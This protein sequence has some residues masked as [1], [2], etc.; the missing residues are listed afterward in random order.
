MKYLYI[1]FFCFSSV[2]L[3]AQEYKM[4]VFDY[5]K[6]YFGENEPLPAEKF[7]M[8]TGGI[9]NNIFF[10]EVQVFNPKRNHNKNEP[11][12]TGEW[13]RGIQNQ[14]ALTYSVPINTKLRQKAQYDVLINFYRDISPEEKDSMRAYIFQGI[15][16]YIEQSYRQKGRK[17]T[18]RNPYKDVI[19]DLNDIVQ[20]RLATYRMRTQIKFKGFSDMVE[21]KV[22]EL[23][24]HKVQKENLNEKR[25]NKQKKLP[26]R[27]QLLQKLMELM[28]GELDYYFQLDIYKLLDDKYIRNY[29]TER[30]RSTVAINIGFGGIPLSF[31]AQNFNY[32]GAPY[33][34]MSFP[35]GRKAFRPFW[36]KMAFSAGVFIPVLF[37][38][39]KTHLTAPFTKIPI[40]AAVSYR[41]WRFLR[42]HA[43]ATVLEKP[44]NGTIVPGLDRDFNVRPFIGV[45]VELDMWLDFA[46]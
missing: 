33:V 43:G 20:G 5:E 4:V 38:K 34:G 1:A 39:H 30:T 21:V 3:F 15:H 42:I 24:E 25:Q 26:T 16:Q 36:H 10:V 27:E 31:N 41:P 2:F 44:V 17:V 13:K 29:P 8:L 35:L 9:T 28:E 40:Y 14:G 45:S 12:Y 37:D 19:K 7:F 6:S 32:T 11:E 46:K 18:W 22:K 23:E